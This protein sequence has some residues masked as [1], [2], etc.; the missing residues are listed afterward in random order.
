MREIWVVFEQQ[1]SSYVTDRAKISY[2]MGM[3]RGKTLAWASAVWES[4]SPVS[5]SFASF[6]SEMK[7]YLTILLA[8]EM[9][10]NASYL[11]V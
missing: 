3:L 6:I 1:P 4:Q 11:Y 10:L 7:K 2:V 5:S 8:V 9:L